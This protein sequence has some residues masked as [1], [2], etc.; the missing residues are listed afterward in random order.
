MLHNS[1]TC[2]T[3]YDFG[4]IFIKSTLE[5]F[6][7]SEVGLCNISKKI[8]ITNTKQQVGHENYLLQKL[9]HHTFVWRAALEIFYT[10]IVYGD[11]SFFMNP[12]K[13]LFVIETSK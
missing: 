3:K 6:I 12:V 9:N 8:R 7:K 2:G 1:R 13:R 4:Q 5:T 11:V 10:V